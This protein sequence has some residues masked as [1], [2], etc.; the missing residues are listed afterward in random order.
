MVLL[1]DWE[2]ISIPI[3]VGCYWEIFLLSLTSLVLPQCEA[4]RTLMRAIVESS[5][6]V[7]D[8]GVADGDQCRYFHS[9]EWKSRSKPRVSM[10][11]V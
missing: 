3:T 2:E 8:F 4:R 5:A 9:V 1:V 11:R 7:A 10:L 6:S